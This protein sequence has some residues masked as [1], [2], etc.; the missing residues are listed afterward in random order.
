MFGE[1]SR[2]QFMAAASGVVSRSLTGDYSF[3][4]RASI[5]DSRRNDSAAVPFRFELQKFQ[6][7]LNRPYAHR[8]VMVATSLS[9]AHRGLGYLE[10]MLSAYSDPYGFDAATGSVHVSAVFYGGDS[11]LLSLDDDAYRKYPLASFLQAEDPRDRGPYS[12]A[13]ADVPWNISADRYRA[14]A[15]RRAATF[16]VCNNSLSA[17]AWTIANNMK[18]R[19][20]SVSRELVV[21]I[22]AD[23]VKHFLPGTM[24]V[25]AGV[26]ALNAIL[27]AGYTL[28]PE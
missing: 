8:Q 16:F 6:A 2:G 9:R 12:Q 22:H 21:I 18:P 26:A 28:L 7:A 24:L 10:N 23:L 1:F 15:E 13:A 4:T 11:F 14:L 19:G 25:P 27:E 17:A 5:A 3:S 20:A